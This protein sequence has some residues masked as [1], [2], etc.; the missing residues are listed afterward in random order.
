MAFDDAYDIEEYIEEQEQGQEPGKLSL[1][2]LS[3]WLIAGGLA[4]LFAT[5]FLISASIR[6]GV[7]QMQAD[8]EPLQATLT[9]INTPPPEVL[10]LQST[11]APLEASVKAL[12]AFTPTL[13]AEHVD[14]AAV[15]P[16]LGS[17]DPTQMTILSLTQNGRELALT[18]RAASEAVVSDYAHSLEAS[19]LFERVAVQSMKTVATPFSVETDTPVVTPP[20]TP[21][22]TATPS[23][24][25]SPTATTTPSP[26]PSPTATATPT[27]DQRDAYEPDEPEPRDIY[28]GQPQLHNF[29]PADD[30]D[31]VRFLAK[32][33]R[34]YRVLTS[35]LAPGVDTFLSARVGD[36]V[37]TNDDAR[38]GTLSSELSFQVTTGQDVQAI[39]EIRNRGS[40]GPKMSYRILVEEFVPTPTTAPTATPPPSTA[41]PMAKSAVVASATPTAAPAGPATST[42]AA[43]F[44]AAILPPAGGRSGRNHLAPVGAYYVA[45]A[46]SIEFV[47]VVVPKAAPL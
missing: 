32:A 1:R 14:W 7:N 5:L 41:T 42:G 20:P 46:E 38:P 45:P 6:S 31:Q 12:S 10:A 3:L 37:Y 44:T 15:M 18:G 19:G 26:M 30:V 13:S 24:V 23:P 28:L 27:R 29:Y 21:L 16:A 40:Y 34:F 8:L 35:D 33:G 39:V 36:A 43:A 47:L 22:P 9:A 17:F 25:P 4:I 2:T 11:L